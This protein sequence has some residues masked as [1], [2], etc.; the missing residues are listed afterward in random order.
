MVAEMI[1]VAKHAIFLSDSNRF[2]QGRY[3]ARLLKVALYKLGLWP[4]ARFIQTKGKMYTFSEEDGVAYS[5][6]VFDSYDQVAAESTRIWL[7]P[8][9]PEHTMV[10]KWS[11]P[12]LTS[13]HVLLCAF[14]D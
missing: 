1:R 11:H 8:T 13:T 4:S 9:S 6:S 7:L 3:S 10:G 5:Y 12:L 2:G 14:K